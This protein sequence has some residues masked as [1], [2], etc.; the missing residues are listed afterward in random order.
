MPATP[1]MRVGLSTGP[2]LLG[3]VGAVGE[4]TALGDTVN[5]EA[6]AGALAELDAVDGGVS[7][8]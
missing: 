4:T 6:I 3:S 7:V 8:E 2:V 5:E 1:G